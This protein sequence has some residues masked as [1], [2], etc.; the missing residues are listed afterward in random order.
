MRA[1]EG[2]AKCLF[3]LGK[4]DAAIEHFR[5]ML[6]LNPNDNQ[7]IRYKL[8][9]CFLEKRDIEAAEELLRQFKDEG[10]AA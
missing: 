1:R 6:R 9:N 3:L 8:L 10:S 7:G 4:H 2:L 5:D